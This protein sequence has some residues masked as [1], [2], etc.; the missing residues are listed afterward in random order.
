VQEIKLKI[1][2]TMHERYHVKWYVDIINRDHL[3]IH[4]CVSNGELEVRTF[5]QNYYKGLVIGNDRTVLRPNAFNNWKANHEL[6]IWIPDKRLAFEYNGNYWH[7]SPD[8]IINDELKRI[9]C[10]KLGIQLITIWEDD[11]KINSDLIKE[12]ILRLLI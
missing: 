8:A 6:D 9:E 7:S 1:S 2:D 5:I 12:N 10:E 4:T 11:W 3:Y